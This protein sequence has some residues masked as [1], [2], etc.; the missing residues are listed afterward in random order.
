MKKSLLI[1]ILMFL[2]IVAT[3]Q[4]YDFGKVSKE[5]ILQKEHPNY[6]DANAS[7]LYRN[8]DTKFG[9]S[10]D[11]G[12]YVKTEVQE[13][14]KI[15][16]QDGYDEATIMLSQYIGER[17]EEQ[18]TGIKAYTY[19]LE[20]DKIVE[21][22]LQSRDIFKEEKSKY[23]KVTKFTMPDISDGSVI[24]YKYTFKSPFYS[25]IDE[26]RF[27]EEIP[28]DRVDMRFFAPEYLI[29]RT[30]GKGVI[31]LNLTT[32]KRNRTLRFR[33]TSTK[34]AEVATSR[35]SNEEVEFIENGYIVN[36]SN[37]PPIK[38][39]PYSGNLNNYM[40]ALKF[41]LAMTKFPNS[42]IRSYATSWE[43]VASKIYQS[44][45][46]GKELDRQSYY[47]KDIDKLIS[48]ASSPTEKMFLIYDYVK[49]KMTWNDYYGVYVDAGVKKAYKDGVGNVADINLMLSSMLR[50]AGIRCSPVL[51]S[52]KN[53][54]IPVFPTRTGFNYVVAGA[55]VNDNL[56]LLDGADKSG[57]PNVLK[58]ELLNWMGRM[59]KADGSSRLID[60]FP[61]R[62]ATHIGML[63][64]EVTDDMIISGN[65]KNRFSGH[66]ARSER[67]KF[68]A[69]TSD[70]QLEKLDSY[71]ES[72]D[73]IDVSFKDLKVGSKP[74]T[75]EYNFEAEEMI[76]EAGD[77]LYINPLA[78]LGTTRNYL[79]AEERSHPVD[80]VYP[81]SDKYTVSIKIPEGYQVESVPDDLAINLV[82][83]MGSYRFG[84][85]VSGD[86]VNVGLQ[87]TMSTALVNSNYYKDLQ[88][89]LK[90]IVAKESE[91]I[92]FKKI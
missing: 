91:K 67:N 21:S 48:S 14:I 29:Y 17:E 55:I 65:A 79:T 5:E 30:H 72:I 63:T 1:T 31:P 78:H 50:Y 11:E 38:N 44:T 35:S 69:L 57:T 12:F 23:R 52:T 32:D 20:G 15:Y 74:L 16:N 66:Y 40:S 41:E 33:Y 80:Y 49:S 70:E 87:N 34:L 90:M 42:E 4:D 10:Q 24:E 43:D 19:N 84:V 73:A 81:W 6:P 83:N 85:T 58:P 37:V 51:L 2:A 39:E 3:A 61:S 71:Y 22:K 26:F 45:G 47:K 82:D 77:K 25:N 60:L 86:K 59:V 76:D 56:Y 75:L 9:Y 68:A 64:L 7:I 13:R 88:A 8:T 54:G 36:L 46:F 27:Q 18:V 92:V 53:N 89:Y 62:P 28:V